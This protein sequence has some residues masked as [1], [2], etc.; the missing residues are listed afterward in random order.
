MSFSRSHRATV[1]VSL[2]NS[3]GYMFDNAVTL[4][5]ND[6]RMV[7]SDGRENLDE[8]P[9]SVDVQPHL[10]TLSTA[11]VRDHGGDTKWFGQNGE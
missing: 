1:S 8:W 2:Y 9:W 3:F 11:N 4:E 6:R 10:L 5:T 7:G